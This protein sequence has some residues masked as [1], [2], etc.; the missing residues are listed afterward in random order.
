MQDDLRKEV[1]S[2][3]DSV[4]KKVDVGLEVVKMSILGGRRS[5]DYTILFGKLHVMSF[6]C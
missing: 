2:R 3:L 4:G 6:Y 5:P 1:Q